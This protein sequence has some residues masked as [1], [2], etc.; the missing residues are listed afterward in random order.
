MPDNFNDTTEVLK[1]IADSLTRIAD[2][3]EAANDRDGSG[4]ETIV[5]RI[6]ER[7]SQLEKTVR[8]IDQVVDTSVL[9]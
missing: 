3:M 2:A 8:D 4:N 9:Y 6:S 7:V 5:E 1:M